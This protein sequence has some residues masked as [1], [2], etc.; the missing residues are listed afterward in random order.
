M[1]IAFYIDLCNPAIVLSENLEK[2]YS[3]F[4]I[5]ILSPLVSSESADQGFLLLNCNIYH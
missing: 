2:K 1:V 4:R 5:N 3:H